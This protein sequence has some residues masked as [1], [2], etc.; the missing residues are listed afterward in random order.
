MT[1]P[2]ALEQE[3]HPAETAILRRAV[4]TPSPDRGNGLRLSALDLVS[5]GRMELDRLDRTRATLLAGDVA[6]ISRS[7]PTSRHGLEAWSSGCSP[8]SGSG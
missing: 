3:T 6:R 5:A 4:V 2:A 7:R 8:F 1:S